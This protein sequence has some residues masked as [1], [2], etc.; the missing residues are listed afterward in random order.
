LAFVVISSL[1]AFALAPQPQDNRVRPSPA[2][3]SSAW[4]PTC[5]S[6]SSINIVSINVCLINECVAKRGYHHLEIKEKK[7]KKK[8]SANIIYSQFSIRAAAIDVPADSS[9]QHFSPNAGP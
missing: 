4:L 5:L 1:F 3:I 8:K 9:E 2:S 6:M 7:K